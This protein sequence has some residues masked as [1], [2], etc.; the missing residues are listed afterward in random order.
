MYSHIG[1]RYSDNNGSISTRPTEYNTTKAH[2]PQRLQPS[3]QKMTPHSRNPSI[4]S[5]QPIK[6]SIL[7]TSP[8]AHAVAP[9]THS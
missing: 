1:K 5:S 6:L 4:H 3:H 8:L 7:E 9:I 2:S